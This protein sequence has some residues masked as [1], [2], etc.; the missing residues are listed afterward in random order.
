MIT[1]ISKPIFFKE[2]VNGGVYPARLSSRIRGEEI[3][4]A[5]GETYTTD[6]TFD[7]GGVRIHLKPRNLRRVK[8][9]DYVDII[10]D[11]K[12]VPQL[13]LRPKV[14]VLTY[15][16]PYYE[17]LRQE[18]PNEV[19]NIPHP[20]INFENKTRTK[21][22]KIIGGM[23]GK[24]APQSYI[25]YEAIRKALAT[26]DVDFKECFTYQ[27]RE[28]MLKFYDLIDFQV[29][30]YDP[31]PQGDSAYFRYPG[32]IINAGAFGIPTIAQ[33]IL[34]HMEMLGFFIPAET[35]E[36]VVKGVEKLKDDAYYDKYSQSILEKVKE[37]HMDKIAELYRKL[38]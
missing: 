29:A 37:Y 5:L 3:A 4:K 30:W 35:L 12:L 17:Y 28:E 19:V 23:V 34:G 10:D 22:K 32:K 21:N 18:L 27:S 33:P 6:G 16:I 25:V 1:F 9:G 20:H 24:S 26:I 2:G 38:T 14:K 7:Q 15:N 36:D 13:K 11:I 31:I 8:D